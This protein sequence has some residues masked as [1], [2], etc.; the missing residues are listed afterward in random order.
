MTN[1]GLCSCG[2]SLGPNNRSGV[3]GPC[4]R[5][6]ACGGKEDPSV[7]RCVQ[8]KT[9][10]CAGCGRLLGPRRRGVTDD[11]CFECRKHITCPNCGKTRLRAAKTAS[12]AVAQKPRD[13]RPLGCRPHHWVVNQN[14]PEC[15]E[16]F[17]TGG[18]CKPCARKYMNEYNRTH[19]TSICKECGT[20]RYRFKKCEVCFPGALRAATN[21]RRR[22]LRKALGKYRTRP[23]HVQ[24]LRYRSPSQMRSG[25]IATTASRIAAQNLRISQ[26]PAPSA[27]ILGRLE[28]NAWSALVSA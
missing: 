23:P 8:C 9:K 5:T 4:R 17:P 14:V 2:G 3:C 15:G 21:E 24:G 22:Q 1:L 26:W 25:L 19:P 16:P 12:T 13:G 20:E 27:V 28:G 11:R 6:C 10:A 18:V 7:D